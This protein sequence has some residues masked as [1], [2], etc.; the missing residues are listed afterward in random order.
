MDR[1][2]GRVEQEIFDR[3]IRGVHSSRPDAIPEVSLSS[4]ESSSS[5]IVEADG[6]GS[7]FVFGGVPVESSL[8]RQYVE[9][10]IAETVA[11]ILAE[12]K[13]RHVPASPPKQTVVQPAPIEITPVPTPQ[14]TPPV[15]PLSPPR[16]TAIVKTPELSPQ[17]SLDEPN[18][19]QESGQMIPF[20]E[21]VT[22]TR[23]PVASPPRVN[24]PTSLIPEDTEEASSIK[25]PPPNPWNNM[26]LP[27]DEENPHSLKEAVQYKD[28]VVMTVAEE[29]E[30]KSLISVT[31]PEPQKPMVPSPKLLSPPRSSSSSSAS[32]EES[33]VTITESDTTDKPLSEGEVL[34]SYGQ[35]IAP[36]AL[37]SGGLVY[38]NMTESLSSTLKD[39]NDMEF[40]TPS[41]GQV[42]DRLLRGAHPDPI[43]SLLAKLNQDSVA[44]RE[45]FYHPESSGDENSMGEIS[46]GQRPCLTPAAEQILVGHSAFMD[47]AH[48]T[49]QAAGHLQ[50]HSSSSGPQM[51]IPGVG[52]GD[53]D[54]I[55]SG[56]MS[57]SDL[58]SQLLPAYYPHAEDLHQIPAA[59]RNTSQGPGEPQ[60]QHQPA[61]TRF[62]QVGVKSSD[63]PQQGI[64]EDSDRTL[65]EPSFYLNYS[66]EAAEPPKKMSVTLP[67]MI[68][69]DE[70]V[71]STFLE[72]DSSGADTF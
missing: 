24:T 70:D 48:R 40:D 46:E 21:V 23:T 9:E 20:T 35:I 67:S 63:D 55:S 6:E 31:A 39:T 57:L 25:S 15:S 62:I 8:M 59:A 50:I 5:D 52:Q 7:Q 37:A 18:F 29:E 13:T 71:K 32:T 34:Y 53:A 65:V 17:T 45:V 10:A 56:P 3:V 1:L 36:R 54:N 4:S 27:L 60:R 64:R 69:D 11:I 43:Q 30:A 47:R 2:V 28:A 22:P 38:P 68:E 26:E 44:R 42:M 49:G 72:S 58:Q 16:E 19:Q 61:P 66:G 41:E 14:C 12:R 33:S 51:N